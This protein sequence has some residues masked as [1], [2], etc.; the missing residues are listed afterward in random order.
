MAITASMTLDG[1]VLTRWTV[2]LPDGKVVFT[3]AETKQRAIAKVLRTRDVLPS[4][5]REST[6]ADLPTLGGWR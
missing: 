4:Q 6:E 1:P 2:T 3:W 5:V